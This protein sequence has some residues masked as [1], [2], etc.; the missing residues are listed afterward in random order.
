MLPFIR[1][2]ASGKVPAI[3]SRCVRGYHVHKDMWNPPVGETVNCKHQDGNPEDP[4]TITLQKDG[5]TVGHVP[6]TILCICTIF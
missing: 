3:F 6:R 1:D 4:Y 2:Q 5:V